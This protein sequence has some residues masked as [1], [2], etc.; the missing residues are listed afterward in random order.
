MRLYFSRSRGNGS[1]TGPA[2]VLGISLSVVVGAATLSPDISKMFPA[3]LR[4]FHQIR[5]PQ[6]ATLPGNL[7]FP[8]FKPPA[9]RADAEYKATDNETLRVQLSKF[10]TDSSAY[11]WFTYLLKRW[12]DGGQS[13]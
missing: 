10:E 12:R 4:G 5:T 1:L 11:S 9:I 13:K 8:G 2:M 7:D 3:E 6:P